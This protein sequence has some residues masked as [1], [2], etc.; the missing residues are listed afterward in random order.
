MQ[1]NP[2]RNNGRILW[3][4]L[5]FAAQLGILLAVMVALGFWADAHWWKGKHIFVLVLPLLVVIGVLVK[6]VKDTSGKE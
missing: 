6:A 3:Q 2:P 5:G 4:Y 1:T